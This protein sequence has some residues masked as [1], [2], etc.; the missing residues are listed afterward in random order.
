M[1]HEDT[2]QLL[3]SQLI[4][5]VHHIHF[6]QQQD[7]PDGLIGLLLQV[8]D[9]Q[10]QI[11]AHVAGRVAADRGLKYQP[12]FVAVS[13]RQRLEDRLHHPVKEFGFGRA[14]QVN[15][16]GDE[17]AVRVVGLAQTIGQMEQQT[18][19]ANAPLAVNHHTVAV[20]NRQDALEL[21]IATEEEIIAPHWLAGH[22]RI[23]FA[24]QRLTRPTPY[25]QPGA[26]A[27][28]AADEHNAHHDQ[29]VDH[30]GEQ[31]R[32]HDGQR[33]FHGRL[34]NGQP[35][36]RY[37]RIVHGVVTRTHL[38]CVGAGCQTAKAY[39][40]AAGGLPIGHARQQAHLEQYAF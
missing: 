40:L 4:V 28:A 36:L 25:A 7:E 29:A 17:D 20:Q 21:F 31:D 38:D 24:L 34:H 22:V 12:Q 5:I 6:I 15:Q 1:L 39:A 2:A 9:D 14:L 19:F 32:T 23:E 13:G 35:R 10:P 30:I 27:Q 11:A 18:G 37:R 16:H 33:H 26:N 3:L 8:A